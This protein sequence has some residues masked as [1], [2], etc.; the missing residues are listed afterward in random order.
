MSTT[1]SVMYIHKYLWAKINIEINANLAQT[2]IL[3]PV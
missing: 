2:T 1:W 3:I